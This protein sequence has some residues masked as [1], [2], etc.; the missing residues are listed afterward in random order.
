MLMSKVVNWLALL[1]RDPKVASSNPAEDDQGY[2][3][4][5]EIALRNHLFLFVCLHN[6]F[7]C[8]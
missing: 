7:S 4:F 2:E 3:L 8:H 6:A 1:L 5:G